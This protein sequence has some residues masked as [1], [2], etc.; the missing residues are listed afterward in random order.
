VN[1]D[2]RLIGILQDHAHERGRYALSER[3]PAALGEGD[4]T[5]Y[6]ADIWQMWQYMAKTQYKDADYPL[7]ATREALQNSIDAIRKLALFAT[8]ARVDSLD[9]ARALLGRSA[10]NP[11][12]DPEV[13]K[14]TPYIKV[15]AER[16][17]KFDAWRAANDKDLPERGKRLAEGRFD[18]TL[19]ED[20]GDLTWADNGAGMDAE[21]IK[22]AFLSLGTSGKT[23]SS[24]EA[25]GFGVAKAVIL[26]AGRDGWDL[27]TR[28]VHAWTDGTATPRLQ[29]NTGVMHGGTTL[30]AHNVALRTKKYGDF[31]E[32]TAYQR[33]ELAL[34]ASDYGAI[35]VTLNGEPVLPLFPKG[36]GS[37][38]SKF[39]NR[40]WGPGTSAKVYKYKR[41]S[42][43]SSG[44]AFYVRLNGLFQFLET[45]D[46]EMPF[47]IVIDIE[48][49][50]RPGSDGY[51]FPPSRDSFKDADEGGS[52]AKTFR[53]IK[54]VLA[55]D[56]ESLKEEDDD[57][58]LFLPTSN[59]AKERDAAK[60][61][62]DAVDSIVDDP[63]CMELANDLIGR[64]MD[65]WKIP[66]RGDK[67]EDAEPESDAPYAGSPQRPPAAETSGGSAH[68][69]GGGGIMQDAPKEITTETSDENLVKAGDA[70]QRVID[71]ADARNLGGSLYYLREARRQLTAHGYIEPSMAEYALD[72]IDEI[73]KGM[74]KLVDA[75]QLDDVGILMRLALGQLAKLIEGAVS[76]DLS[77]SEQDVREVKKKREKINPFGTAALIR[78]SKTNYGLDK[79][80]A[81]RSNVQSGHAKAMAFQRNAKQFF[82]LLVV[83]EHTCKMIAAEYDRQLAAARLG[84][85]KTTFTRKDKGQYGN[86]TVVTVTSDEVNM[87]VPPF[88]VGYVLDDTCMAMAMNEP[89]YGQFV[90]LHPDRFQEVFEHH[91]EY[92]AA[93]ASY[94]HSIACHELAHLPRMGMGHTEPYVIA[95]EDLDI[96]TTHLIPVIEAAL[97]RA[98]K[99]P[100]AAPGKRGA[101]KNNPA[102]LPDAAEVRSGGAGSTALKKKLAE[103]ERKWAAEADTLR[104]QLIAAEAGRVATVELAEKR[105]NDAD[106]W[107]TR[108]GQ[109]RE[110]MYAAQAEAKRL[111]ELLGGEERTN[112]L[113]D[114]IEAGLNYA[115]FAAALLRQVHAVLPRLSAYATAFVHDPRNQDELVARFEAKLTKKRLGAEP[116][117][118]VETPKHNYDGWKS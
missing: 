82:P 32:Y 37:V 51:P 68:G 87:R 74:G 35:Q 98:F 47:D 108:N 116:E 93:I 16:E 44:G 96:K 48:T 36:R 56:Q 22:R 42:W 7:V 63:A 23:T 25:G 31:G 81:A 72:K 66:K 95:R 40:S 20:T 6:D 102:Y 88:G 97:H 94:L 104:A 103:Q 19:D 76:R 3:L 58:E 79:A 59:T 50:A 43:K 100:E 34:R 14:K 2:P 80:T 57:Y 89:T 111:K 9:E 1:I 78:I 77:V 5:P 52:A 71:W 69:S 105:S 15:D 4:E 115:D 65:D 53:Y 106:Y 13:L 118:P 61:Y 83:W 24:I 101:N 112:R 107:Q 84:A 86:E 38:L 109:S 45:P 10:K 11:S 21:L 67:G 92:P 8:W 18:V 73:N 12:T 85:K 41:V 26:L 113:L 64:R 49:T 99:R 90:L 110:A 39:A 29:I 60:G 55:T 54:Y 91:R 114:R 117:A 70:F 46:G 75:N 28:D 62:A 27:R 17:A 33:I 30:V